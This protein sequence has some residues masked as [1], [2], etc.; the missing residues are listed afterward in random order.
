[1]DG[2]GAAGGAM[3]DATPLTAALITARRAELLGKKR[4]AYTDFEKIGG[5]D[6][7]A[8]QLG[9]YGHMGGCN[10]YVYKTV[11]A[12]GGCGGEPLAMKVCLNM[13]NHQMSVAVGKEFEKEWKVLLEVLPPHPNIVA[14]YS[15]FRA[16]A[17]GLPGWD[18]D[19]TVVQA[20][21]QFVMMPF[22][23]RDL[24]Q[25]ISGMRE[26]GK[27][28]SEP[29]ARK[30]CCDML[31][32]VAHL[33]AH[34][35]AHRDLKPD[36]VLLANPNT[37]GEAA[38]ITD[39]GV[40]FDFGSAEGMPG[41]RLP[42]PTDEMPKGGAQDALAPE[43]QRLRPSVAPMPSL[44]YE[45]NDQWCVGLIVHE[46]MAGEQNHAF[47]DDGTNGDWWR[48]SAAGAN[49]DAYQEVDEVAFGAAAAAIVPDGQ[50][51]GFAVPLT[52]V[53]KGLLTVDVAER[54]ETGAALAALEELAEPLAEP[55]PP[56]PPPV[57]VPEVISH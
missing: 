51:V 29:R 55:P 36:N 26:Q 35:V 24:K 52:R 39:F 21:T 11:C 43:I 15:Q 30:I 45:K 32:G 12:G 57:V 53:V 28:W 3:P 19:P 10:S 40:C 4:D 41:M 2:G 38:I 44:D 14:V 54:L 18:F 6:P 1:M 17:T 22:Y 5:N 33:Q 31:R 23:S 27:A 37:P 50:M 34:R 49:D 20:K 47:P 56:P 48:E 7:M 8:A 46:L 13:T 42:Y 25:Q 9:G 16:D